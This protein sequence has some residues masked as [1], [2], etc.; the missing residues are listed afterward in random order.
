MNI[1]PMNYRVVK[2]ITIYLVV[3]LVVGYLART[4]DAFRQPHEY[5][6]L[7]LNQDSVLICG[8]SCG[9][10]GSW[11]SVPE[12]R[13][14]CSQY[15]FVTINEG[16]EDSVREETVARYETLGHNMCGIGR[17]KRPWWQRVVG[18]AGHNHFSSKN[19]RKVISVQTS[20]GL[21]TDRDELNAHLRACDLDFNV[22]TN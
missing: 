9:K 8:E 14:Y 5:G 1:Q 16:H 18:I 10:V 13:F 15:G 17:M 7:S 3:L 22:I 4:V 6:I 11:S 21:I 12:A 20:S 2:G 19:G